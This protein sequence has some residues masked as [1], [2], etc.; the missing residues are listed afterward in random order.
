MLPETLRRGGRKLLIASIG[1]AT[2]TY[3]GTNCSVTSVA[4]LQAPPSCDVA[5]TN[6]Y[7]TDPK[8]DAAGDADQDAGDAD[9]ADTTG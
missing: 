1:V 3:V 7:C 4:N 2:V 5:P 9:G 8:S 6:P